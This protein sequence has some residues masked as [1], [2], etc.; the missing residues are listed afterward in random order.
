MNTQAVQNEINS[1]IEANHSKIGGR[2]ARKQAPIAKH[3]IATLTELGI[4]DMVPNA[5]YSKYIGYS[6]AK[7]VIEAAQDAGGK[8]YVSNYD[9]VSKS[10]A[11]NLYMLLNTPEPAEEMADH[12]ITA[13]DGDEVELGD[14][15]IRVVITPVYSGGEDELSIQV[16]GW[17]NNDADTMSRT[18]LFAGDYE[19]EV[20]T[21][22]LPDDGDFRTDDEVT[23]TLTQKQ[24][25]D[26]LALYDE[27][28][29]S[30]NS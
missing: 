23:F 15:T 6:D 4:L 2:A 26:A 30:E 19:V 20:A 3:Q 11:S 18:D 17:R 25:D 28:Y 27:L 1:I 13:A 10:A 7:A 22:H 5:P 16:Y 9:D 12:T 14:L 29:M 21:I 8:V 24:V